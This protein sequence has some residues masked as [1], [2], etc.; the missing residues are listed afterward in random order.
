M[1]KAARQLGW[2]VTTIGRAGTRPGTVVAVQDTR[3][4]PDAFRAVVSG[5]TND[6]RHCSATTS[7]TPARPGHRQ[8]HFWSPVNAPVPGLDRR[9]A[10]IVHRVEEGTQ[11][12]H[13]P[14]PGG[15]GRAQALENELYTRPREPQEANEDLRETQGRNRNVALALQE[16]M[17]HRSRR[18]G[19]PMMATGAS[20][21]LRSTVMV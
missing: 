18:A 10:L 21:A 17:L 3:E 1:R 11:L 19:Q 6:R 4:V 8:E 13:A 9:A 2:K 14:G 7:R 5:A 15:S 12:I 20:Q 16:A